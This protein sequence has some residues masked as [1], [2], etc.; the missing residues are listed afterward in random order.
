MKWFRIACAIDISLDL[1][2]EWNAFFAAVLLR[3]E[4]CG[5]AIDFDVDADLLHG[6]PENFGRVE[7]SKVVDVKKP[8]R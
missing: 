1:N 6:V 8:V 2:P 4:L 7:Q 5:N 3:G